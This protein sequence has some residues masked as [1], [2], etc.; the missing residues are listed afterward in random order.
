MKWIIQDKVYT[1]PFTTKKS[2]LRFLNSDIKIC[3]ICSKV[4][5]D[6]KHVEKCKEKHVITEQIRRDNL[7]K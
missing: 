1:L 7:W 6:L 3:P 5:T 4:D 2:L